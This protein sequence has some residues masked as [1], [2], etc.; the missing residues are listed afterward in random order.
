MLHRRDFLLRT[1]SGSSLLALGPV[2]PQFI[3]NTAQAAEVGKETV[4]VVVQ[5]GGGND[6]LN[7]VIPYAD[8][9]YQKARP[10][11]GYGKGEVIPLN[12]QLGLNPGLRSF[13]PLWMQ[14]QLAVV[15]GVGYPNP[16]RSHFESMDIWQTGDPTRKLSNGWLARTAPELKI[17]R[18]VPIM[19]VGGGRLPLALQGAPDAAVSVNDK[20]PYR[21]ELG[22]GSK[23][24]H[25]ARR[26]LLTDLAQEETK[27]PEQDLLA[28]VQSRQVET[29]TTLDRLEA[30][31]EKNRSQRRFL[32]RQDGGGFRA[33]QQGSLPQ[34]LQLVADLI[35]AELGTRIFYVSLGGFDTH[36]R[37]KDTHRSVLAEVADGI[38]NFFTMLEPGGHNKRVQVMTFSEF[39]RRVRENGS[40]GTDHGSGSC[41]FVAGPSIK[42][43]VVGEHPSLE[44]LTQGDLRYHTDFRRIYATLLD[45]WLGCESRHVLG[46]SFEHVE[47]LQAKKV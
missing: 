18:G 34:Q 16:N 20:Q 37:Q 41:L 31:L 1:L 22:G 19:H 40:Q 14:G 35:K 10:T 25:E 7:T 12:D 21:L 17:K 39:G 30:V 42:G 46:D 28:F 9:L 11:L 26:R 45:T 15:Q 38:G 2:V 27:A 6:G 33:Y 23:Q 8:D 43:G 13:Q 29:L 4:L 44:D 5:L 3:A 47:G 32:R 24:R 36:S